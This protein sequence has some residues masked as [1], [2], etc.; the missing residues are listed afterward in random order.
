MLSR[1][2]SL[3]E[4]SRTR[5]FETGRFRA[6]A[7]AIVRAG[8]VA[9]EPTVARPPAAP[10]CATSHSAL[11]DPPADFL[12]VRADKLEATAPERSQ[13]SSVWRSLVAGT[14]RSRVQHEK[15]EERDQDVAKEGGCA[16]RHDA[17][18][19]L[20]FSCAECSWDKLEKRER[21]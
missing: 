14:T 21:D 20:A 8:D 11:L 1:C 17:E 7:T 15:V 6:G 2:S 9:L 5:S 4:G 19:A 18:M 13:R 10:A 16:T 3:A 12:P